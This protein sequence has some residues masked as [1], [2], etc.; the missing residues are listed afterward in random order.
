MTQFVAIIM[1]M[2]LLL[3]N[4]NKVMCIFA[5]LA[6]KRL[7]DVTQNNSKEAQNWFIKDILLGFLKE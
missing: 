5:D 3:D 7:Q 1:Q 2:A 6:I 4:W